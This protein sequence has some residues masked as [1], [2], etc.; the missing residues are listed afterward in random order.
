MDKMKQELPDLPYDKSALNPIISEE[1]FD[2][3]HGWFVILNLKEQM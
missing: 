2:Y 1:A 3:H